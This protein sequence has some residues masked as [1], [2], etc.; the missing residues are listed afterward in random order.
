V[1]LIVNKLFIVNNLNILVLLQH[2]IKIKNM[3]L[4]IL[5]TN[6]TANT[7][8]LTYY[9]LDTYLRSNTNRNV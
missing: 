6:F 9:L 3:V 7:L 1:V 8:G 2:I 5:I 4:Y